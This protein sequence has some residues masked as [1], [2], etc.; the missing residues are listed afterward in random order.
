M[1]KRNPIWMTGGTF[2]VFFLAFSA[3]TPFLAI[4]YESVGLTGK[5]IGL[6]AALPSIARIIFTP[7]WGGLAD[8]LQ[9]QHRLLT[10]ALFGTGAAGFA[11][12]LG[13]RFTTIFLAVICWSIMIA[14]IVPLLDSGTLRV[15]DGRAEKY[16]RVR[17]WGSIGWI[18]GTVVFGRLL[19]A[20]GFAPI[21]ICYLVGMIISTLFSLSLPSGKTTQHNYW[22]TLRQLL[23]DPRWVRFLAL[24]MVCG[25]A[26]TWFN[27]YL[28]LRIRAVGGSNAAVGIAFAL[29]ALSEVVFFYFGEQLQ[30]WRSTQT[31]LLFALGAYAVRMV[32]TGWLTVPIFIIAVQL[33]HGITYGLVQLAAVPFAN[34]I[35]PENL[36][37]TAQSLL[38]VVMGLGSILGAFI[39][40]F[41]LDAVGLETAFQIG[42]GIVALAL[43][44]F[45]IS[46]KIRP[47]A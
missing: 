43:A 38:S 29:A 44:G 23:T 8:I 42:G 41:L 4:Y 47:R 37:A 26:A 46:F 25:F 3:I 30:K 6:L 31:F 39:G 16:G 2:F 5:Q 35:A 24:I 22:T 19:D 40:G 9:K 18:I 14:P 28:G 20:A 27:A 7:L 13:G 45:I 15:L 34:E 21:F 12:F 17:L 10:A 1:L 32:A 36:K 33:L 11:I